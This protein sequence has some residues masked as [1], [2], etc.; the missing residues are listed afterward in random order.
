VGFVPLPEGERVR[1]R[2]YEADSCR[3]F[4]KTSEE[5]NRFPSTHSSLQRGEEEN[6]IG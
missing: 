4:K 3:S 5:S 6:E 1:V 2:G